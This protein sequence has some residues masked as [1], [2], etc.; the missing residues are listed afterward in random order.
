MVEDFQTETGVL[1]DIEKNDIPTIGREPCDWGFEV[2]I[3]GCF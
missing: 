3:T 1:V 2:T